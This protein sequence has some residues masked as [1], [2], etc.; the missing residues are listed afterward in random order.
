[1]VS[2]LVW[3]AL[4]AQTMAALLFL[5][6][7]IQLSIIQTLQ[8]IL[9]AVA[10]AVGTSLGGRVAVRVAVRALLAIKAVLEVLEVAVGA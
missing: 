3:A 4:G 8:L 5:L 10:V 2:L 9:V 6:V 1:M 7:L